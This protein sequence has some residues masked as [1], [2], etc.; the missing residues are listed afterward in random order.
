[1]IGDYDKAL[2]YQMQALSVSQ[3]LETEQVIESYRGLGKIYA[4]MKKYDTA[5]KNYQKAIMLSGKK[6]ISRANLYDSLGKLYLHEGKLLLAEKSL[7]SAQ[8]IYTNSGRFVDRNYS[9]EILGKVYLSAA[10]YDKA[11]SH[12]KFALINYKQINDL[13]GQAL[14]YTDMAWAY[15]KKNMLKKSLQ[16]N[17]LALQMRE[18][19]NDSLMYASSLRNIG[20]LYKDWGKY[21][22]ALDYFEKSLAVLKNLEYS[23]SIKYS[24]S[25]YTDISEIYKLSNNFQKAYEYLKMA[26]IAKNKM[27]ERSRLDDLNNIHMKYYVDQKNREFNQLIDEARIKEL[28]LSNLRKIRYILFAFII[29]LIFWLR[30]I[31]KRYKLKNAV[32]SQLEETVRDRV[33]DLR[34]EIKEREQTQVLLQIAKDQAVKANQAK[35]EFLANMSHEIRTPMNGIIGFTRLLFNE[36]LSTGVREKMNYIKNSAVHLL[37]IIND[38]LDL[39]KIESGKLIIEQ[40]S[41]NMWEILHEVVITFKEECR[42]RKIWLEVDI[43]KRLNI[44]MLGD[45]V[46]IKQVMYNLL[47]NAVKFTHAGGV[48]LIAQLV[49][50]TDMYHVRIHVR[51]TGIGIAAE[52]QDYIFDDFAQADTSMTRKY[53]GTGLGLSITRQLVN[54][55]NGFVS[56]KST[57][58]KGS[59]FSVDIKLEKDEEMKNEEVSV[60]GCRVLI[61]DDDPINQK[62][63]AAYLKKLACIYQVCVNGPTVLAEL[64]SKKY[65]V[66]LLDI[67]MPGMSGVEVLEKIRAND[68]YKEMVI[69]MI[70]A[71]S[72]GEEDANMRA[73]GADDYLS[74][75]IEF[76][77]LHDALIREYAIRK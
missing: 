13:R 11:I 31:Y 59:K 19:N 10:E 34:K 21:T 24:V 66:L 64:A 46:R 43:D 14:C 2:H 44:K 47:S 54:K 26:Q 67:V 53:G 29:I 28:S 68:E 70:S 4:E 62:I 65:D 42:E 12:Y 58:N 61:A 76:T 5:Q 7:K 6:S 37:N 45:P 25:A 51:D 17:Q 30:E 74:K 1:M 52:K 39:S 57:E 35:T 41:F 49:D 22:D 3:T 20:T 63:L 73:K 15:Y 69:I 27:I 77:A 32:N 55:M 48:N 18:A 72:A 40:V 50:E 75:P 33:K 23:S 16:Y 71:F 8:E 60:S 38:L 36:D 9:L 56:L